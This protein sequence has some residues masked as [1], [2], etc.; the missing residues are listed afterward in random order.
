MGNPEGKPLFGDSTASGTQVDGLKKITSDSMSVIH[1]MPGMM[2]E[3]PGGM[4][5]LMDYLAKN[6]KCET[7]NKHGSTG[8]KIVFSMVIRSDGSVD[9][10]ELL[11]DEIGL[12]CA[13]EVKRVIMKMPLWKPGMQGDCAVHV[14]YILPVFFEK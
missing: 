6:I 3:Y 12:Q 14:K 10:V 13:D 4:Q 9:N 5:A 8:G 1:I 2:P 7:W 11:R